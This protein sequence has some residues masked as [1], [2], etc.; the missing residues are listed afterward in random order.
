MNLE[1]EEALRKGG[2]EK[3]AGRSQRAYQ[4]YE[5]IL[6]I[7]PGHPNANFN[8]GLLEVE[9]GSLQKALSFFKKS[10]KYKSSSS[11]YWISYIDTLIKLGKLDKA[12]IILDQFRNLI[13]IENFGNKL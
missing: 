3:K 5:S 12:H 4:I 8:L 6:K 11:Q 2:K 10:L 13:E 7:D 1:I 9:L